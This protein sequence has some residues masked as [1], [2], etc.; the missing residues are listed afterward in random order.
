VVAGPPGIEDRLAIANMT[1]EWEALVGLF[2]ADEVTI[3]WLRQRV[4]KLEHNQ[5]AHP[6]PNL[7]PTPPGA[8]FEHPRINDRRIDALVASPLLPSPHATYAKHLVLDLST[9]SPR[10]WL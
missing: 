7:P 10:F 4:W 8:F 6:N 9:L 5:H 2:P 1:T 3:A